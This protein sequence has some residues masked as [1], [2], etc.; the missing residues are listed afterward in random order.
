MNTV[1]SKDGTSIAFDRAGAGP[2]VVLISGGPSDRSGNAQL[3]ELLAPHVTVYNYD[4]RGRGDSGDTPPYA[5]DRDYEDLA[6]VIAEAGGAAAC[7]ATPA[8]ATS[9]GR[10]R[11][12]GFRSP[13]WHCGTAVHPP[14]QSSRG[15]KDWGRRVDELVSAGRAGDALEYGWRPSRCRRSCSMVAR[16]HG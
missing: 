9:R 1:T 10:R 2:P 15:A 5:V 16:C 3:A 6:A 13:S 11:R 14:R 7:L 4:R 8:P 12:A